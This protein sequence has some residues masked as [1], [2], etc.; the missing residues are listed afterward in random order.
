MGAGSFG[1]PWAAPALGKSRSTPPA[2]CV[3]SGWRGG[4][5]ESTT[6]CLHRLE[7]Q[8]SWGGYCGCAVWRAWPASKQQGCFSGRRWRGE[9]CARLRGHGEGAELSS[10]ALGGEGYLERLCVPTVSLTPCR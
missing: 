6:V 1:Q 4:D 8:L 9:R 10:S 3:A 5:R 7:R 2:R